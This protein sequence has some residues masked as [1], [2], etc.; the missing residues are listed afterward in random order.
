MPRVS[1]IL[2]VKWVVSLVLLWLLY[3][4]YTILTSPAGTLSDSADAAIVL[5][6]A[7]SNNTPS[8]VFEER[9]NHAIKLYQ[10][11]NVRKLIFTG[12]YG[13]N[14]QFAE[15]TVARDYAIGQGL[16][17]Q[18]IVTETESHITKQNLIQAQHLLS[19][20]NLLTSAIVSGPPHMKRAMMIAADLG[21]KAIPSATPSSRYQS[22]KTR[23]PF[24]LRELYFYH[25]YL[26]F[27]E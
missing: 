8:P 1:L 7:V 21:L 6:A 14:K 24:P 26:L 20:K 10:A 23:V 13:E 12:G 27:R 22:I 19:S 9:I 25:H 17:S 11:S 4:I 18:D 3:L 16:P 15:S 5:G 2:L